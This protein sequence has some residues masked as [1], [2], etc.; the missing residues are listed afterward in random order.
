MRKSRVKLNEAAGEQGIEVHGEVIDGGAAAFG[1]IFG[2]RAGLGVEKSSD[3]ADSCS[4]FRAN[5]DNAV[6]GRN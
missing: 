2:A 5:F 4:F 3:I 6:A 1:N